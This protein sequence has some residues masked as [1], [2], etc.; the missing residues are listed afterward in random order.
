M[1]A[2]HIMMI[3]LQRLVIPVCWV[4]INIILCGSTTTNSDTYSWVL[5][6]FYNRYVPPVQDLK[7]WKH[8][9][10]A[11]TACLSQMRAPYDNLVSFV[12]GDLDPTACL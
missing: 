5:L 8:K 12:D 11:F 7:C 9:F 3:F 4:G 10:P 1:R 6:H 2:D